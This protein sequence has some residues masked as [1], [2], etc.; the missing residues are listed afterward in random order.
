MPVL[1][2]LFHDAFTTGK[3]RAWHYR[4]GPNSPKS[5]CGMKTRY[6]FNRDA[7]EEEPNTFKFPPEHATICSKCQALSLAPVERK[8]REWQAR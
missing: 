2:P 5:L 6:R 1:N 3:K 8:V 4:S 7:G